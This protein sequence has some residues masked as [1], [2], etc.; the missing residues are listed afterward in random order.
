MAPEVFTWFHLQ[1]PHTELCDDCK[2][3]SLAKNFRK[4]VLAENKNWFKNW[5]LKS[6]HCTLFASLNL[7]FECE[8]D[9]W[10]TSNN[11]FD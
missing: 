8:T 6:V 4:N 11:M 7:T 2:L 9:V 3:L 5:I 1:C 10:V